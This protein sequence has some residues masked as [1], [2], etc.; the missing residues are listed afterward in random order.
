MWVGGRK[1]LEIDETATES[2]EMGRET[3]GR[4]EG[5]K[6][7]REGKKGKREKRH[8]PSLSLTQGLRP[9]H[10]NLAEI[11]PLHVKSANRVTEIIL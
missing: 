3:E 2:R 9:L 10:E 11:L 7:G 5:R 4:K 6:E 8:S 1:R